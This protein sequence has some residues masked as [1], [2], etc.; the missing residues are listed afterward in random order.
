MLASDIFG[1]EGVGC[2]CWE[3]S[4]I[5]H[6]KYLHRTN[7][8]FQMFSHAPTFLSTDTMFAKLWS[9]AIQSLPFTIGYNSQIRYQAMNIKLLNN[10]ASRRLNWFNPL[11]FQV[12]TFKIPVFKN[13]D[14]FCHFSRETTLW[15]SLYKFYTPS[16]KSHAA[17]V[18]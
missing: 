2:C 12:K 16:L 6:A 8:M 4:N 15:I 13:F 3:G 10:T 1:C 9:I 7:R 17:C 18:T 5:F 14:C 11:N